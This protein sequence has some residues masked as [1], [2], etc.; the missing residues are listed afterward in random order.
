MGSTQASGFGIPAAVGEAL[1]H[2]PQF[3]PTLAFTFGLNLLQ[4][5]LADAENLRALH[6][7]AIRIQVTDAGLKLTFTVGPEGFRPLASSTQPDVTIS[8]RAYDFTMLAARKEDPDT[9]F[10]HRRLLIE[11]DTELG[12][13]IKNTLDAQEPPQL[14][15][16]TL[17][18]RR[19]L[20]ALWATLHR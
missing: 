18:P 20:G 2:L 3:P 10:F 7:R 12:L 1:S 9:L 19:V 5:Q 14:G 8:A 6:G 16:A 17:A 11:G 4:R 13:L 15:L